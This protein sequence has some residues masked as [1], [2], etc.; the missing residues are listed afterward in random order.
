ML[1]GEVDAYAEAKLGV[2]LTRHLDA[3]DAWNLWFNQ[4]DSAFVRFNVTAPQGARLALLARR[5]E[6]PSLTARDLAE[7]VATDSRRPY[8]RSAVVSAFR[9]CFLRSLKNC[10]ILVRAY[11]L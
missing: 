11:E 8:R 3:H 9:N 10:G 6:P 1:P 4:P 2:R 5:N 7:I